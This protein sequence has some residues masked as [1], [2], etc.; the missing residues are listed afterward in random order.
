[1]RTFLAFPKSFN[2]TVLK[3]R[4]TKVFCL[5]F[6]YIDERDMIDRVM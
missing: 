4:Y 6:F 5:S 3:L 2:Q 1:M